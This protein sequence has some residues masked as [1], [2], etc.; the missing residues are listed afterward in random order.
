MLQ[1]GESL[2]RERSIDFFVLG[3]FIVLGNVIIVWLDPSE[4]SHM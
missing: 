3:D 2:G 4:S 1:V